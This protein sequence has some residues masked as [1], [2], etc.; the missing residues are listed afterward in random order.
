MLTN[1]KDIE[2][3]LRIAILD[4]PSVYIVIDGIDECPRDERKHIT[5]WFRELIE[6]LDPRDQDRIRCLFVSQ[7]DGVARKDFSGLENLKIEPADNKKDIEHFS[8][9]EASQIQSE[10]QLDTELTAKIASKIQD[11]AGGACSFVFFFYLLMLSHLAVPRVHPLLLFSLPFRLAISLS[12]V[13]FDQP[14]IVHRYVL[15]S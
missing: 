6:G 10:F 14:D 8:K 5:V 13:P 9:A 3:L 2:E 12:S 7:D 11:A 15:V 1:M 4:C